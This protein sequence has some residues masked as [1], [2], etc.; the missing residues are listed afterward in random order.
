MLGI[1]TTDPPPPAVVQVNAGV[2]S[3]LDWRYV[4]DIDR[5]VFVWRVRGTEEVTDLSDSIGHVDESA[6]AEPLV[7]GDKS[8]DVGLRNSLR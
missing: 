7:A 5:T 4:G 1:D 3:K 6:D 2:G 8:A